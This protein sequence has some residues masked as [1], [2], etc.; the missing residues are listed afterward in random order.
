LKTRGGRG[1]GAKR[2]RVQ[3]W[4]K[5]KIEKRKQNVSPNVG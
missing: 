3:E 4:G 5:T 1:R 2:D